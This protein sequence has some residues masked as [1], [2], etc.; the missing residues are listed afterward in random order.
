MPQQAIESGRSAARTL[1]DFGRISEELGTYMKKHA[2]HLIFYLPNS[3][4]SA[5]IRI[6]ADLFAISLVDAQTSPQTFGSDL[7]ILKTTILKIS[8]FEEKLKQD[9]YPIYRKN[10]KENKK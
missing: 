7:E 6:Q 3:L 5:L 4:Y 8:N 2:G 9:I 1:P 10:K